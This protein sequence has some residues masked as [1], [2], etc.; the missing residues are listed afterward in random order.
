MA[1]TLA[2]DHIR[3]LQP[4]LLNVPE[5]QQLAD[6]FIASNPVQCVP[7][8]RTALRNDDIV[9]LASNIVIAMLAPCFWSALDRDTET[10]AQEALQTYPGEILVAALVNDSLQVCSHRRCCDHFICQ[11]SHVLSRVGASGASE[12]GHSGS[13]C[14]VP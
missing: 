14:S 11:F 9:R 5:L 6:L 2:E 13:S 12:I 8:A 7:L 3:A 1:W 4:P 10:E